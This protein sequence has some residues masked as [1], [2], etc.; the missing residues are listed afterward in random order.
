MK[1]VNMFAADS[2]YTLESKI[3][4]FLELSSNIKIDQITYQ[5]NATGS[6]HYGTHYL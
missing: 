5:M 4:T 1:K 3:N 2:L 6:N